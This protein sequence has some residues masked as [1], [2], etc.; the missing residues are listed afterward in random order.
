MPFPGADPRGLWVRLRLSLGF[1]WMCSRGPRW[2]KGTGFL[3]LCLLVWL[4]IFFHLK[5][6]LGLKVPNEV[7]NFKGRLTLNLNKKKGWFVENSAADSFWAVEHSGRAWSLVTGQQNAFLSKYG[8]YDLWKS[9]W[10][11]IPVI[12][13]SLKNILFLSTSDTPSTARKQM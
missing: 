4:F 3:N 13:N 5:W 1:F 8:K 7:K 10:Y 6:D 2:I 11:D 9:S 12:R